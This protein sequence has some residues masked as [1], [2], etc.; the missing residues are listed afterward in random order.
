[1]I[2]SNSNNTTININVREIFKVLFINKFK[3]IFFTSFAT[4]L[5]IIYSQTIP[6]EY[7]SKAILAEQN[8]SSQSI[9]NQYRRVA[10]L[11]GFAFA[12]ASDSNKLSI[13]IEKVKSLDFFKNFISKHDLFYTLIGVSGWD[14]SKNLLINNDD[15][16]DEINN[17]WIADIPFAVQGK[18]SIQTAHKEFLSKFSIS[19]D[20]KTNFTIISMKHYS[21]NVAKNILDLIILE[22]NSTTKIADIELSRRT[23]EFLE[24]EISTTNLSDIKSGLNE[25]IKENIKKIALANSSP[26]YLLQVVSSPIAPEYKSSPKRSLIVFLTFIFS[27]FLSSLATCIPV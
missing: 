3:I 26:E 6:D 19:N 10:S 16:F 12:S 5:S 4:L 18:P 1:M 27:L 23:I 20:P 13:A 8:S 9:P 17:K 22:V 14:K 15:Y 21:P 7:I 11:A 2:Q 25:L 24:N